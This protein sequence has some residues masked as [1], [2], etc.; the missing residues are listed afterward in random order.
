[1]T[2]AL[3][4]GVCGGIGAAVAR[5]LM[6]QGWRVYGIDVADTE[7]P[8]G[9]L[10]ARADLA[11]LAVV[12]GLFGG[13]SGLG[14]VAAV[15][16]A[17]AVQLPGGI[18]ETG[19][20]QWSELLTVNVVAGAEIV[21]ALL[22][23]L[24]RNRG[25]VV[26]IAS[27]HARATSSGLLAYATAKAAL[28][29]LT[30][31]LAVELAPHGVRANAV[32]PG[33]VDTAMLREG[34]SRS[35]DVELALSAIAGRTPLGRIGTPEDIAELTVFLLDSTRSAFITGQE[36]VADGGVLS[37]LSSEAMLPDSVV[38]PQ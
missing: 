6:A 29:G 17:A 14:D 9:V 20:A 27:V 23:P 21:R 3:V 38:A 31:A 37:L 10:R 33:A 13:L 16:H 12:P 22:G 8:P 4:T 25:A 36:F 1:M 19:P 2:A 28:V 30:R 11:D 18:A 34:L 35:D 5:R 26:N 32:S 7:A 24:V 15:V